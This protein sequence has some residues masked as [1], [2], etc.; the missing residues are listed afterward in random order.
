[1]QHDY[2]TYSEVSRL[3]NI[4]IGTLYSL[5]SKRQI[6]HIRLGHRTVRF[7]KSE[8]LRWIERS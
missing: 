1:M 4:K 2:L 7:S 6:P 8:I 5:V 3:L